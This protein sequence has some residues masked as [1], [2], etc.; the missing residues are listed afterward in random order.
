MKNLIKRIFGFAN[1]PARTPK[2]DTYATLVAAQIAALAA[3]V[4]A[5]VAVRQWA[6]VKPADAM[7]D[8]AESQGILKFLVE[9]EANK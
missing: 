2:Q 5:T 8:Y 7:A 3:L 1:A 6:G 9:S 4:N